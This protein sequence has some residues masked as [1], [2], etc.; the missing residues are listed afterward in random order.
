M[1]NIIMLCFYIELNYA[2]SQNA[3]CHYAECHDTECLGADGEGRTKVLEA[4]LGQ[5]HKTFYTRKHYC[6]VIS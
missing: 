1:L 4:K 3:E 2:E 6:I 5:N